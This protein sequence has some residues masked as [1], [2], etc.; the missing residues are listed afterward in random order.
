MTDVFGFLWA[1]WSW[2]TALLGGPV[3]WFYAAAGRKGA[4]WA[5]AAVAGLLLIYAGLG[6][7][8]DYVQRERDAAT[9]ACNAAHALAGLKAVAEEHERQ[10]GLLA[11]QYRKG[12]ADAQG[13]A[14]DAAARETETETVIREVV[15]TVSASCQYTPDQAE[16]L[17]AL[18][19]DP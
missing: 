2:L 1:N 11:E 17:N 8:G 3:A 14:E 19:R 9:T 18:R 16:K 13:R 15:K 5:V 4:A 12:V 6:A 10:A 7:A